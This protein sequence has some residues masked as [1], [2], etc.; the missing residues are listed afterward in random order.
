MNLNVVRLESGFIRKVN[1]RSLSAQA[2]IRSSGCKMFS[3]I[4]DYEASDAMFGWPLEGNC[5][6]MS[7]G[8]LMA[9]GGGVRGAGWLQTSEAG[10]CEIKGRPLDPKRGMQNFEKNRRELP[11]RCICG[12][13]EKKGL[14][15][16]KKRPLHQILCKTQN[17][18]LNGTTK[19]TQTING[20]VAPHQRCIENDIR[21]ILLHIY[22]VAKM[23]RE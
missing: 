8:P 11:R 17:Y 5:F 18:I 2:R 14:A 6:E 21:S 22:V 13:S 12:A 10:V 1:L 20:T 19:Q 15:L 3:H 23:Y 16:F 4:R 7:R 9:M